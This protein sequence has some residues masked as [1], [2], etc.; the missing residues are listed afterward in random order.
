M[1]ID[2]LYQSFLKTGYITVTLVFI[3]GHYFPGCNSWIG[4]ETRV[5]IQ[6]HWRDLTVRPNRY[7]WRARLGQKWSGE[8][9]LTTMVKSDHSWYYCQ[10]GAIFTSHV[11]QGIQTLLML[12]Q[13]FFS[14]NSFQNSVR[15]PNVYHLHKKNAA[16]RDMSSAVCASSM[17][18]SLAPT[19]IY[20]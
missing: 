10:F 17:C 14:L 7:Q 3:K 5:Q 13:L 8:R 1:T 11:G 16:K 12:Y 20:M 19:P 9:L 2:F 6:R 15:F 18:K 4:K